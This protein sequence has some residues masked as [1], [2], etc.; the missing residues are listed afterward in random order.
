MQ[1]VESYLNNLAKLLPAGQRED[2]LRE[3]SEDIH[4]EIEDKESELGHKLSEA[5]QLEILKR[6]G[7]PLQI[8]A[9]YTQNKGT[10][11]F[12]PQLIGPVLFP[13]YV[14]V[15]LF[16]V[17]LTL[18]VLGSV[19]AVF[20]LSGQRIH[21]TEFLSNVLFQIFVQLFAVTVIFILV[22]RHLDSHSYGYKPA[23]A[24]A[25]DLEARI[26]EAAAKPRKQEVS[27][28]D[29]IAVLVASSVALLWMQ[30]LWV[31]PFLV[32]GP[33]ASLITFAPVWH[34]VYFPAVFLM[35]LTI[36]RACINIAQPNWI[37]FRDSIAVFLDIG[38]LVILYI[39][40]SAHTW[41]VPVAAA[42]A[43][44]G[45]QHFAF[46]INQWMPYALWV[47]AAITLGQTLHDVVRLYKNWRWGSIA[48]RMQ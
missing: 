25:A 46:V 18:L 16:N 15:L 45:A 47:A 41:V 23:K 3:L 38:G 4:S 33:A 22:E 44:T 39:L 17:G 5:E 6:R 35:L 26:R 2:I 28:F 7:T 10:F 1:P 29:S 8:A 32:F 19:F 11:A 36:V 20:S 12:G 34:V 14:R 42:A 9:G 40:L 30:S 13:F 21:T 24:Q 31:K 43:N 27:R 37:R 48:S